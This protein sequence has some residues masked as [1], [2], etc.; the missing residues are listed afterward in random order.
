MPAMLDGAGHVVQPD[1]VSIYYKRL[2]ASDPK[3]SLT[4][5]DPKAEGNCVPI[6]NALRFIMGFDMLTGTAPTGDTHWNCQGPTATPGSYLTMAEAI[7]ACPYVPGAAKQNQIGAVIVAPSCWDGKNLDSPNH[8]SHV[9]YMS[10]GSWGYK[11]CDAA[12]PYVIPTFQLGAWYT[13][14][15]NLSKWH[16]A[17]DEMMPGAAPGST[18]HAD[19]FEGW[20]NTVKDMWTDNCINKML[21]CSG[22][23]LGNGLQLKGADKPSY[24]WR[25]PNRLVPIP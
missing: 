8:R 4:S 17:S 18:F 11:K 14:D 25:N 12:H 7:S 23:D 6:P 16:F 3:C 2:P 5:G 20:D 19:Y 15:E 10:Y 1:Y 9:G 13:V 22:G 24:G 21:N